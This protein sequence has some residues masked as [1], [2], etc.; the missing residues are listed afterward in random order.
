MHPK[1]LIARRIA[2]E[3]KEG[4]V[5]NLGFGI[6]NQAQNYVPEDLDVILQTENGGL[7][8]GASPTVDTLDP[9][10]SNSGGMPITLTKGASLFDIQTSFAYIRG[11]H[12]DLSVLGALEVDQY[13][14]IAN[15]NIPGEFAPGMGGAMDLL[16]G[17]KYVVAS[18]MHTDKEGNSKLLEECTLPL[19]APKV[20]DR[21]ITELAVFDIEDNKFV[22]KEVAPGAT[23]DE[24]IDKTA[25]EVV[26]P[27]D[28]KEMLK[29]K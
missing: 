1:E 26:V 13:G 23:V 8:F 19:S 24:I 14:N 16:V 29:D 9:D 25:G 6:P 5:V 10:L 11:G 18:L 7:R 28:V 27:D 12:V 15:W 20:V 4:D 2:K 3:F 17:A 22:L 21:V